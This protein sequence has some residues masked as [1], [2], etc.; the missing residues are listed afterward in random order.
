ML[1]ALQRNIFCLHESW[2]HEGPGGSSGGSAASVAGLAVAS[3]GT[4]TG[5]SIRQPASFCKLWIK[6]YLW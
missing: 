4:D 5:S 2:D 6:A 1:W 3:V